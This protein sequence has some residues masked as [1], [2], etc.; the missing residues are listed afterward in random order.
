VRESEELYRSLLAA[1]GYSVAR[2]N[3]E[4]RRTFAMGAIPQMFGQTNEEFLAGRFGDGM[5][6]ED[7]DKAQA[8]LRETFETGA[9]RKGVISRG[10]AGDGIR[11]HT[12]DWHP[13]RNEKGD[14]V[15]VQATVLDITDQIRTEQRRMQ[16][17]RLEAM[18]TM[19]GGIAHDVNNSLAMIALWA[20]IAEGK[21]QEAGMQEAL[22]NIVQATHDCAESMRRLRRF[23]Q[24]ARAG[25]YERVNLN[26]IAR[27]CI[28][29][30][31]P[32]WKDEAQVKDIHITVR[33]ELVE[34]PDTMGNAAELRESVVNLITNA[35]EA[36]PRGGTISFATYTEG[37]RVCLAVSDTGTGIPEEI[38]T[39]I[40]D[41]FFTTKP[42][43]VGTGLGLAVSHGIVEEHGGSLTFES[44]A[45][46]WTRFYLDLPIG[47]PIEGRT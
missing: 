19:A 9:P 27:E 10:V 4:G 41:P 43:G 39:R 36:M 25:R 11:Y 8:L 28:E 21:T 35:V 47:P 5:L 6:P 34:V 24:P 13:I 16:V 40:F 12:S 29:F 31:K 33:D 26:D 42:S 7:R 37:E 15:E 30:T 45:G 46:D 23:S 14:V 44:E 20:S 2:V 32:M 22:R 1:T 18:G 17:E 38:V 3:R